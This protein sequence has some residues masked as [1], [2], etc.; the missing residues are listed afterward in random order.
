MDHVLSLPCRKVLD[1]FFKIDY[2][3]DNE[4]HYVVKARKTLNEALLNGHTVEEVLYRV[5]QT[6]PP[7]SI[8]IVL[9]MV[10][11]FEDCVEYIHE[12]R[13]VIAV[14]N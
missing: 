9:E 12:V 6:A 4:N 13:S 7:E 14:Q 10:A 5:I 1:L 2:P 3:V 11:R 8:C